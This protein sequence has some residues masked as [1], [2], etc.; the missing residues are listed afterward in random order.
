MGHS[1]RNSNGLSEQQSVGVFND[2]LVT[3]FG[4]N[5][6]N[7]LELGNPYLQYGDWM[8]CLKEDGKVINRLRINRKQDQKVTIHP[9]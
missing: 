1:G 6:F 5:K 9:A 7:E 8:A 3:R 2:Y 4:V